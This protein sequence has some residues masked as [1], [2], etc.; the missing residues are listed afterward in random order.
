MTATV[1]TDVFEALRRMIA[2]HCGI[3]VPDTKAA[4]LRT[5]LGEHAAQLGIASLE[6]YL[7][8]LTAEPAGG[9]LWQEVFRRV[10]TGETYFFRNT[11]QIKAF[12]DHLLPDTIRSQEGRMFRRLKLWS[13]GCA[14]GEEAYTLA[15]LLLEALGSE[16]A[17]WQPQIL[18]T[19]IDPASIAHAETGHYSGRAVSR[20]PRTLLSRH[21]ERD[22]E[23][24][25]VAPPVRALVQFRVLNFADRA[26]MAAQAQLDVIFCRNVLIYFDGDFRRRVVGHLYESLKPGGYL[27]IGHAESLRGIHGGFKTVR[28]PGTVLYQRPEA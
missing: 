23:G 14:S 10:T 28:F 5:R 24:Y 20:V 26:Q 8:R 25:R 27:V 4:T 2:R 15:I 16:A 9:P 3:V 11:A 19:D 1:D 21:F 6:A 22:G 17:R 7:G 12:T 13:A 18:A